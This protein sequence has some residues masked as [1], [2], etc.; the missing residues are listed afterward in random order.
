MIATN[1][2]L[3]AAI[4]AALALVCGQARAATPELIEAARKEGEVTWYTTQ[5]VNQLVMPVKTVFE[6]KYG[7]KINYVRANT[8]DVVLRVLN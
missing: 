5:I 4:A 1:P 6:K 3:G 7:V 2:R 8:G